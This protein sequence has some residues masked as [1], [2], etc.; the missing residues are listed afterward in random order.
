MGKPEYSWFT[1]P[2]LAKRWEKWG[3]T[4][5]DIEHYVDS[6][7]LYYIGS[8]PTEDITIPNFQAIGDFTDYIELAEVLRFEREALSTFEPNTESTL[9]DNQSVVSVEDYLEQNADAPI[10]EKI[11]WLKNNYG[12]TYRQ[13]GDILQIGPNDSKSK[14][15]KQTTY[16]R[17]QEYLR[18]KTK[19]F[20]SDAV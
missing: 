18:D 1:V 14:S 20:T 11:D 15:R 8:G 17:H 4:E 10:G 5:D 19:V 9:T 12:L 13:I 3:I 7:R 2:Q 6:Y 16:N